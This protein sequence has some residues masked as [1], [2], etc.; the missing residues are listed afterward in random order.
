MGKKRLHGMIPAIV[1]PLTKSG[2]VDKVALKRI[3]DKIMDNGGNGV[4]VLGTT[5]EG[6]LHRK[7]VAVDMIEASVDIIGKRGDVIAGTTAMTMEQSIYYA[8]A[9]S[10]AG[11]SAVL[12]IPPFYFSLDDEE[13]VRYYS[14][15]ADRCR[16]PVMIYHMPSV[17]RRMIGLDAVKRLSLHGN[18]KGIKDSSG[19]FLFFQELAGEFEKNPD[20]SVFMGKAL[21]IYSALAAGADGTM[22][23][24]GNFIPDLE[25]KIYQLFERKDLESARKV[26]G[27]IFRI[28]QELNG[29]GRDLGTTINGLLSIKGITANCT[30]DYIEP[31]PLSEAGKLDEKIQQILK[32]TFDTEDQYKGKKCGMKGLHH[33]GLAVSDI[34]KSISFYVENFGFILEKQ[35]INPRNGAKVALLNG[36]GFTYELIEYAEKAE[37]KEGPYNHIAVLVNNVEEIIERFE[38]KKIWLDDKVP[39]T[40]M[41][42]SGRIVFTCGPDGELIELHQRIG[43]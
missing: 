43:R 23:P 19:N 4:M 8:D 39:R 15:Y 40:I 31:M 10:S 35:W 21:L 11:A 22:T 24:A 41:Q 5:G 34:E 32:E 33:I 36:T 28:F 16:I 12:N 6:P 18:I 20:F 42:G 37:K 1:T 26:Q 29:N 2:A 38:K 3:I 7:E 27:K 17:S 25:Q 30:P 9:A 13:I 14:K